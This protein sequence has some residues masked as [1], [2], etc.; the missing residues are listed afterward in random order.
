MRPAYQFEKERR[1]LALGLPWARLLLRPL[2]IF[3]YFEPTIS[4]QDF[5]DAPV[6]DGDVLVGQVRD[7]E[8]LAAGG[9]LEEDAENAY[10]EVEL[11]DEESAQAVLTY[12]YMF[13]LQPEHRK[14]GSMVALARLAAEHGVDV[15]F[16]ISSGQRGTGRTLPG[17]CV[18]RTLRRQC[19]GGAVPA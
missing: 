15:I 18:Q 11:A 13:K 9:G 14:L 5:L 7:F 2:E 3:G 17:A 1:I 8:T 10:R 16:Y 6:Y 19:P 4:R 12:H